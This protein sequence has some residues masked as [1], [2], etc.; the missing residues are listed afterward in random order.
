MTST[1]DLLDR[2]YGRRSP[3]RT[4]RALIVV[5]VLAAM[6]VGVAGWWVVTDPD[7][8]VRADGTAFSVVDE[9]TVSV[10]FQLTAPLGREV[11]CAIEA[12]D[13]EYGVVGWK[14]VEYP[15]ADVSVRA[16]TEIIPTLGEATT[17]LVNTCWVT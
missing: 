3:R 15:A 14:V 10:T 6:V 17:G 16:F 13:A 5:G 1:Q 7:N 4:R 9:H 12:L 11:A 8:G 2:R